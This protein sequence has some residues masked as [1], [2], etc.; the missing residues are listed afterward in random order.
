[1]RAVSGGAGLNM[2]E[3]GGKRRFWFCTVVGGQWQNGI[4]VCYGLLGLLISWALQLWPIN[5]SPLEGRL[6]SPFVLPIVIFHFLLLFLSTNYSK[7]HNLVLEIQSTSCH[8]KKKIVQQI[9]S[10]GYQVVKFEYDFEGRREIR[11]KISLLA[12]INYN[13]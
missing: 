9:S 6:L 3:R 5:H 10:F 8:Q 2:E 13:S 4:F 1:M 11:N 12:M 7:I